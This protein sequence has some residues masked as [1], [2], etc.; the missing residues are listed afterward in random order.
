MGSSVESNT[1]TSED[2]SMGSSKESSRGSIKYQFMRS[3]NEIQDE[4]ADTKGIQQSSVSA[5]RPRTGVT[6]V[7]FSSQVMWVWFVPSSHSCQRIRI[8]S[9]NKA[10]DLSMVCSILSLAGIF[11]PGWHGTR[12]MWAWFVPSSHSLDFSFTAVGED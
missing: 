12:V 5:A 6:Q 4:R 9:I 3:D 1:G 2:A 8:P 10:S 11:V 7:V